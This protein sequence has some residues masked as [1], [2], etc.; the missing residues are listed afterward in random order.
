MFDAQKGQQ[1]VSN[2]FIHAL[3]PD[4]A[5]HGI[6]VGELVVDFPASKG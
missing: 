4:D 2:E 5:S 1:T 3:M 6:I